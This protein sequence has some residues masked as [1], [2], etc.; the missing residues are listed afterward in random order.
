M[1]VGA[2]RGRG[3]LRRGEVAGELDIEPVL[4]GVWIHPWRELDDV[5]EDHGPGLE[6]VPFARAEDGD[7]QEVRASGNDVLEAP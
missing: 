1:E 7:G 5:V 2:I 4:P 6:D 3:D